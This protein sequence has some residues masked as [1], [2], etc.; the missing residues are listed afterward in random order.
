MI[1]TEL[2]ES[3]ILYLLLVYRTVGMECVLYVCLITILQCLVN[4]IMKFARNEI[5]HKIEISSNYFHASYTSVSAV[6]CR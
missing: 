3:N 2:I 5:H 6:I 1:V 4:L